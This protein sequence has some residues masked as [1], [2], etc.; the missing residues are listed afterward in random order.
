[1]SQ[2]IDRKSRPKSLLRH[3]R[4]V[5]SAGCG[6]Q[7]S[8]RVNSPLYRSHSPNRTSC[9]RSH[10][11]HHAMG[12][13]NSTAMR[14]I[15]E[16]GIGRPQRTVS[17]ADVDRL[18]AEVARNKSTIDAQQAIQVLRGIAKQAKVLRS[19]DRRA[20]S[21]FLRC[22]YSPAMRGAQIRFSAMRSAAHHHSPRSSG[23]KRRRSNW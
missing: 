17:S 12:A 13:G 4:A 18:W 21:R 20:L 1:M 16:L 3:K 5:F 9:D 14:A 7:T 6:T 23:M 15:D 22:I 2:K 8:S 11:S 10:H 19:L